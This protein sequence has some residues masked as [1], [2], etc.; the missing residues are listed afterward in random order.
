[1]MPLVLENK[2]KQDSSLVDIIVVPCYFACRGATST[3]KDKSNH[4]YPA[5]LLDNQ[6]LLLR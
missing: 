5:A 2:Q 3:D 6:H 4:L 1:M